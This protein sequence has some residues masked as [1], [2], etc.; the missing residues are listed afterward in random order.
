MAIATLTNTS[1]GVLNKLDVHEGGSLA[2]GGQVK[3][4]LPYPF[5]WV[6]QT[7]AS[8]DVGLADAGTAV[9]AM[10]PQDFNYKPLLWKAL[11]PIDEMKQMLMAGQVTLTFAAETD[12]AAVHKEELLIATL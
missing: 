2:V 12:S 6:G 11:A 3:D 4:P 9:Y 10:H 5:N 7:A 1:G 8:G